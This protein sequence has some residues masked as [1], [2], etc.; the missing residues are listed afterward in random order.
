MQSD[1]YESNFILL[2]V[3]QFFQHQLLKMLIIFLLH[4]QCQMSVIAS[5]HVQS[6]ILSHFYMSGFVPVILF[7]YYISIIHLV[8]WNDSSSSIILLFQI[9]FIYQNLF[10]FHMIFLEIVCEDY[11]R[12][13]MG[14]CM[15]SVVTFSKM[16]ISIM[17]ILPIYG[18]ETFFQFL[19]FLSSNI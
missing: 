12:Y 8:A 6:S 1:R 3:I 11:Y 16:L 4:C 2:H 7:Y 14:E 13:F 10:W 9:C 17:L 15:K 5:T 19:V 18:Q